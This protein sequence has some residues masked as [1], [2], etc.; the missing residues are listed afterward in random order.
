MTARA[1]G[2]PLSEIN[3]LASCLPWSLRGRNL[4]ESLE[5][6]PELKDSPLKSEE[7][8]VRLA[9][10][11]TGLPFQCSVHLG[12]VI[13][14]PDH[15]NSWTPVGLS[16]KGLPVSHL[17]KDDVEAL[18][19][20]KLDLLGLRM[21]T[22]IGKAMEVLRR[23]GVSLDVERVPLNDS[24]TYALLRSTESV[25]VFQV[26]S[27]GQRNLLGRLQPRRFSDL[28]AEISLFRPGPV[29]GNMVDSY[30]FRRNGEEEASI[31]HPDLAPVLSETYGIILFQEQVLRVAHIFAGLSYAEADAFRRAMTKDRKSMKMERLKDRFIKGALQKGH[32]EE[33]IERIFEQIAAFASYGFCKAH[34][35]SFSHITYQSAYLKAHYPQAFYLGILNAGHVGSYPASLIINE[36]RRRGIPIH[37]PHV[38]ASGTEYLADGSGIRVPLTVIN[39]LGEATARRIMKERR[40]RGPFTSE[41]DFMMRISPSRRIMKFL[42]LARAL[43]SLEEYGET[44]QYSGICKNAR[45]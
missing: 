15:I 2:Y 18:G 5:N 43:G 9:S 27:P 4:L 44:R 3:R 6:L 25:G 20:L 45:N 41:S 33:L 28:V 34:A 8:L 21:H 16:P 32:N 37:G 26:E 22:A 12:G 39:N 11:L 17:D 1:L 36:A 10:R 30:V 24:R 13:I 14:A 38:N 35:A 40:N 19:L 42:R 31:P 7:Q 29:E 23:H